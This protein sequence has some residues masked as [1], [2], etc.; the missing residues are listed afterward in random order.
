MHVKQQH[1]GQMQLLICSILIFSSINL[2]KLLVQKRGIVGSLVLISI[3]IKKHCKTVSIAHWM[4][5]QNKL[6]TVNPIMNAIA[7]KNIGLSISLLS[8]L[9]KVVFAAIP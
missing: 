4:I 1:N 6:A 5:M 9:R 8:V 2:F 7:A 3:S